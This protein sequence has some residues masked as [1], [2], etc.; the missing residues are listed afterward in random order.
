MEKTNEDRLNEQFQTFIINYA[1]AYNNS[2]GWLLALLSHVIQ[3]MKG[4]M[5]NVP[6]PKGHSFEKLLEVFYDE[7]YTM[8][9]I[10]NI[11]IS[12][13]TL[14]KNI[15]SLK[16]YKLILVLRYFMFFVHMCNIIYK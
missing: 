1:N 11:Y 12:I 14:R 7:D 3:I 16:V 8:I 5:K 4:D 13:R 10:N 2:P 15:Q 6:I 9:F